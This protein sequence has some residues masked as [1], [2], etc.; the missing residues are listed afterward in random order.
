M[1][2]TPAAAISAN[3]PGQFRRTLEQH[4]RR[5]SIAKFNALAKPWHV[6][7]IKERDV[8]TAGKCIG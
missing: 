2:S 6:H 5:D 1:R 3:S 8:G 7:V 4:A